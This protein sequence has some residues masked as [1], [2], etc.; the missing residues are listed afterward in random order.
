MKIIRFKGTRINMSKLISTQRI[1]TSA[2]TSSMKENIAPR[3]TV[4]YQ[5]LMDPATVRIEGERN[6]N[7]LFKKFL[8]K[9][10]N[11]EEIEFVR[12]EKYYEPYIVIS[13]RHLIDYYRKCT[14]SICVDENVKEVILLNRTFTPDHSPYLS[15]C[16]NEIKLDGEERLVKETRD[17]LVLDRY[18]EDTKLSQIPSAVS[19]E[20]PQEMIKT[21]QMPEVTPD[22]DLQV[23]HR[24]IVQHPNNISRIVNEELEID[25]RSVIYTPRFRLT[26]RCQR[27]DKENHI[28]FDGITLK[29]VK[30][31][32]SAFSRAVNTVTSVPKYLVDISEKWITKKLLP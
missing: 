25:E 2:T 1:I 23:I 9:I 10:T 3:R 17:F 30:Q 12:M 31:K 27:I 14:Y 20:N 32:Q 13:G 19:E 8:F 6:K 18:G 29:R 11:P 21:F 22:L 28:D 26:Y 16:K 15:T 5:T 7:K 4:V 24:K